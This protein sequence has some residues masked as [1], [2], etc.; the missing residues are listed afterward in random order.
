[1]IRDV[2]LPAY[3]NE[4]QTFESLSSKAL[5]MDWMGE[6]DDVGTGPVEPEGQGA[7]SQP[8]LYF[9]P[10]Y[11]QTCSEKRPCTYSQTWLKELFGHQNKV[12]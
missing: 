2:C 8:P 9:G 12:P 11:K 3:E 6:I 4:E 10:N 5:L 7:F 1:M